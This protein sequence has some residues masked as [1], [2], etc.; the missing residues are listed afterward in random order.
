[1]SG[2]RTKLA[3]GAL[4]LVGT[5]LAAC[6]GGASSSTS[7]SSQPPASGAA[8]AEQT[9][10]A[11]GELTPLIVGAVPSLDLGLIEVAK[12]QGLF[13]QA[14][15]SVE[16]VPVD[17]GP[18]VVTG[19]VAGQYD[20]GATAYAP[21]LLALAE[22]APL[23]L[24]NGVGTVGPEGTN[25]GLLVR[26]DSGIATWKDL[27][28]KKIASNA[29]RSLFSLTVPAAITADGGDASGIEI[30]PLPFN[31]IP[32]AVADGQ[33]DAG[34]VL[35]PFLTAGLAE[36]PDLVDL[37]DSIYAVL[38]E[39]S[40][41]GLYFTSAESK[42]AKGPAIDGFQ[43]AIAKAI[44]YANENLDEVKA[45]GAPL[46]GL[47]PEQAAAL[48]LSPFQPEITAEGLQSLIDL[49]V[50]FGWIAQAPDLGSFLH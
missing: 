12:Q 9:A 28:G 36:Y 5:L 15:V 14:G 16:I 32:K 18:N 17:S 41:V 26:S 27:A 1:M 35:E 19:V 37:G 13:E 40:G 22:G 31:Q 50:E 24:V 39:G 44:G 2:S 6:G 43:Q 8:S 47:T 48:P 4:A 3:A 30:V 7:S 34:V 46:A 10:E 11:N 25:G 45:A 23:A 21:P 20:I 49:M 38:P 29:P 33:V 42:A